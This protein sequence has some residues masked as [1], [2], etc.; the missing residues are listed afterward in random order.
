MNKILID[1][2]FLAAA[3]TLKLACEKIYNNQNSIE[4]IAEKLKNFELDKILFI[5]KKDLT[6][7]L[8]QV[9][10][11]Y[12]I[13]IEYPE[14]EIK[15]YKDLLNALNILVGKNNIDNII[16]LYADY[17]FVDTDKINSMLKLHNSNLTEY[18]FG[19][20]Y[21]TGL[22]PEILS[23]DFLKKIIEYDLK[24]PDILSRRVFDNTT[25]DINKFFIEVDIAEVDFSIKRIELT[26]NSKRN[27]KL[28]KNILQYSHPS[29]SY[30][31]IYNT[32]NK[33]PEVLHIFPKYVEIEITNRCNMRCSFCPRQLMTRQEQDMNFELYKKIIDELTENYDDIIVAY[34][35]FGEPLLHPEFKNFVKYT[36]ENSNIFS[37]IIETNAVLMTD[38]MIKFLSAFPPDKLIIIFGVDAIKPETYEKIRISN[39]NKNLFSTVKTNI[40]K[41]LTF[42][43]INKYRSFIQIL[44]LKDNFLEIEDFYNYWKKFT[45]NII[46]QKYN[47]YINQLPDKSITDLTPLD[48][49]PCW[50]LQRDLEIFSNGTVPLCKQII[51]DTNIIGNLNNEKIIDIW[52]KL[53]TPFRDNYHTDFNKINICRKCDEWYTYNF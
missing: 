21:V 22:V 50:H 20:N 18:T 41:F 33:H 40:E 3:N 2:T 51:N 25:A 53:K 27:I 26:A 43:D 44:K 49:L 23:A 1:T 24:K 45:D 32:I 10:R 17:I 48:R 28:L 16:L 37:L 13:S 52:N 46:I 39:D 9:C 15:N 31:E 4:I 30:I 7:E 36:I 29:K 34:S 35:L 5:N 19:E 12:N 8:E 11:Q 14:I 6:S 38:D 42:N 47:N